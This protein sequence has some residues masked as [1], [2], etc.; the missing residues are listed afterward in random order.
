MTHFLQAGCV[1]IFVDEFV[2]KIENLSLALSEGLQW[3]LLREILIHYTQTKSEAQEFY[4]L[5]LELSY[6]RVPVDL[7]ARFPGCVDVIG[8][9]LNWV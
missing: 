3:S 2:K 5:F 1:A 9:G 4:Y 7:P 6:M 8:F